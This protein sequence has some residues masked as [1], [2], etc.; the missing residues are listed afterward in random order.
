MLPDPRTDAET[1]SS[2]HAKALELVRDD[3]RKQEV[4][5]SQLPNQKDMVEY[6]S[7]EDM[8]SDW[9][10]LQAWG[11]QHGIDIHANIQG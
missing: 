5:E 8:M 3:L 6:H 7:K 11:H 1:R 4:P 10:K 9:Q 2:R